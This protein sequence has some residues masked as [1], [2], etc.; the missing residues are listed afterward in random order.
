MTPS[1]GAVL[2]VDSTPRILAQPTSVVVAPGATTNFTVS[3]EGPTLNFQWWHDGNIVVGATNSSL[4]IGPALAGAQGGY[5]AVIA[6]FAGNVTSAVATLTF[7]ASALSILVQPQDQSVESGYPATFT[8]VASG[9]TPFTYQWQHSGT[10]VPGATTSALTLTSAH[11]G[12]AGSYLAIVSNGYA[13]VQSSAAQLTITPGAVAPLLIVGS[14]GDTLTITFTGEAG[15]RYRLLSSSD[16]VGWTSIAT[17]TPLAPGLVQFT[18]PI[19]NVGGV[20]YQ[21]VTP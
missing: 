12:D 2:V 16:F 18:A 9:V 14:L 1:H 21:V 11:S 17:N 4:T 19:S 20:F 15:R 5:W 7:D 6:N 13:V 10:V 8:V 3:A